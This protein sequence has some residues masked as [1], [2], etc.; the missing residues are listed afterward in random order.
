MK[1]THTR[2][3]L[4]MLFA[5]LLI[6]LTA[7]EAQAP[8]VPGGVTLKPLNAAMVDDVLRSSNGATHARIEFIN[9]GRRA[10][11]I[12]WINYDGRR[13]LYVAG[14]AAGSRCTIRTF[15]THPW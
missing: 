9:R 3:A 7:L 12:Y 4:A 5:H 14:L 6:G 15:L 1:N 2:M 8:A 11:D 13:V 10:V